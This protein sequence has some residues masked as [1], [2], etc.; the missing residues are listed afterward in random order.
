ME[1][2]EDLS[3]NMDGGGGVEV[4][5]TDLESQLERGANW[6]FWIAG[7]SLINSGPG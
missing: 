5:K 6:F 4:A 1:E 7:L 3:Q 2:L